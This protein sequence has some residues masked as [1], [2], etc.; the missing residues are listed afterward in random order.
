VSRARLRP[1][2]RSL[3]ELAVALLLLVL[4]TRPSTL[5]ELSVT[6]GAVAI[7]LSVI[8]VVYGWAERR[9]PPSRALLAT[10]LTAATVGALLALLIGRLIP[11]DE[12]RD[13][14]L[15]LTLGGAVIGALLLGLYVL[16]VRHPRALEEARAL[17]LEAELSTVRGRLEPHF[18]LNSLNAIA[19][20]VGENPAQ[21]R[22]A[23]AALGGLLAEALE[24]A[25]ER[26][27]TL[28]AEL[29]WLRAYVVIFEARYG[30]DLTV[31]WDVAPGLE[32]VVVP[33]LLLQPLV[34]NALLHGIAASGAGTLT[35]TVRRESAAVIIEVS[36][37]GPAV[38]EEDVVPGH[39]LTLVRRRM[40]LELPGARLQLMPGA[41]EG[42]VARL[43]LPGA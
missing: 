6:V 13:A 19:G 22:R 41:V 15:V 36:N 10:A 20:L 40:A 32:E 9:W 37:S 18:L 23:L 26:V 12:P 30:A 14:P 7:E 28:D 29:A 3:L 2:A 35:I 39:G 43:E 38:R 21:A 34:E 8:A 27:H 17:R 11:T 1:A 16:V 25:P 42:T 31:E 33:R 5:T 24:R 4:V